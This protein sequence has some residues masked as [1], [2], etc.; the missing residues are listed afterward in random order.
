MDTC[1]HP[2]L[3]FSGTGRT[4]Q[5]TAISGFGICIWNRAAGEAVT[6]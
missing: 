5:E 3:Y 2:L 4:S 6:G 1:E